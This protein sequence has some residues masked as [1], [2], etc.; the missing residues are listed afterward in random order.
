MVVFSSPPVLTEGGTR[1][2]TESPPN[3][4]VSAG[5]SACP[6]AASVVATGSDCGLQRTAP[7][8]HFD[9]EATSPAR[10]APS[11]SCLSP[12]APSSSTTYDPALIP[13]HVLATE[14]WGTTALV[15]TL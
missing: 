7:S 1:R 11:T 4:S 2:L 9:V 15:T 5:T 13:G 14:G 6:A 3:T 10:H 8:E 12:M